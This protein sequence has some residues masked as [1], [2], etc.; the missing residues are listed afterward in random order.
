MIAVGFGKKFGALKRFGADCAREMMRMEGDIVVEA[1][2][3]AT[4]GLFAAYT[5]GFDW[6]GRSHGWLVVGHW[7]LVV[8]VLFF[9]FFFFAQNDRE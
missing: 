4:D 1:D 3:S 5:N 6:N 9:V 7:P 8:Y 2:V